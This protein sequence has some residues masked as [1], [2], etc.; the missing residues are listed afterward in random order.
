M[1]M[2]MKMMKTMSQCLLLLGLA[3]TYTAAGP[4]TEHTDMCVFNVFSFTF[5]FI[6]ELFFFL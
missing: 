6:I 4:G 5:K 1:K 2:M 3:V